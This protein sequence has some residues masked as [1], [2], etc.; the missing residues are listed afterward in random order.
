MSTPGDASTSLRTQAGAARRRSRG[1]GKSR[2]PRPSDFIKQVLG[3]PVIVKL[4]NGTDYRGT[5]A[6]LEPPWLAGRPCEPARSSL[7]A[8]RRLPTRIWDALRGM[9]RGEA[10]P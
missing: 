9:T 5:L 2:S 3:K 8:L 1:R 4:N 7:K 6:C 10:P